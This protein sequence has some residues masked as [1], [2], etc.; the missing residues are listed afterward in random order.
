M[1]KQLRIVITL[2]DIM[3]ILSCQKS[4]AYRIAVNI[5]IECGKTRTQ[6]LTIYDFCR[7]TGISLEEA[8]LFVF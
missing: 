6:Y 1:E 3:S 2:Q 4:N 8:R 7:V 5:R